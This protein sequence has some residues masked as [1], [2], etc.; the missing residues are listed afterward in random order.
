MNAQLPLR[1]VLLLSMMAATLILQ[2]S[3]ARSVS[4][5]I[6]IGPLLLSPDAKNLA[7]LSVCIGTACPAP[8]ATCPGGGLCETD[9]SRDIDH[10]GS[11][12]PCPRPPK[13][14][15]ATSVCSNSKCAF[16]CDKLYADCNHSDLDGCEVYTG[17]DPKNCGSC[18]N[19]CK[20]GEVCWRGACGCPSGFTR[21]GDECVQ[22]ESDPSSCGTCGK[23]CEPPKSDDAAWSCGPLVQPPNTTWGCA[24]SSCTLQCN[25]LFGDC[26]G[27]L[28]SDGCETDERT[29]PKNCGACGHAC[30]AGQDCVQG[31]CLCPPG[32]TR[33][34]NRCV[35]V[36]IDP[37]N[38]GECGHRCPGPGGGVPGESANGSPTCSAGRCG[39]LCFTG[40]ADC[41]GRIFNGCEV[42]IGSDPRHCGSCSTQCNA[43]VSQPC[44]LGQCLTKPCE[45]ESVIR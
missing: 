43:D 10:C 36:D 3:C 27:N 19:A 44:I 33:C 16:A 22:L 31:T 28:C 32:T 8:W 4:S 26:N 20:E 11:C 9:T 12:A 6:E 39:Y 29:D 2:A 30:A 41:D 15:H 40:F 5:E 13:T 34:G 23:L 1:A 35:D 17:D 42:N 24:T 18:G 14:R 7:P 37:R 25:P 21:C 45:P 38:C